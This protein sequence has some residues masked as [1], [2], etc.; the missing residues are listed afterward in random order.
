MIEAMKTFLLSE[1]SIAYF[2]RFCC[3]DTNSNFVIYVTSLL[4]SKRLKKNLKSMKKS[5][6]QKEQFYQRVGDWR[7]RLPSDKTALSKMVAASPA[8]VYK[9]LRN[10]LVFGGL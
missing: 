7:Q 1:K 3:D 10:Y 5:G 4:Q 9:N 8:K 2:S 6:T